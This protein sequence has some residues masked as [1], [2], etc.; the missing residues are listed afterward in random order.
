[1]VLS[2]HGAFDGA[3]AWALRIAMEE[4]PS[5][6]FVVDLTHAE[7]ACEFAAG[8]LAAWVRRWGRLKRVRFRAGSAEHA[9]ILEGHGLELAAEETAP[10]RGL[11]LALPAGWP[12]TT[13]GAS[14]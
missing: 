2:V 3:S 9:R 14:A 4:T 1:M 10:D 13:S 6:E 11:G 8:L 12:A 7:E 5:R